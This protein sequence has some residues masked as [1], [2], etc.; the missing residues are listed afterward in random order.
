[1]DDSHSA[2]IESQASNSSIEKETSAYMVG[3]PEETAKRLEQM[4]KHQMDILSS[5]QRSID[6]LKHMLEKL[7]EERAR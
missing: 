1:M 7:L 6:S 5:Q 4:Q 3:A 2:V